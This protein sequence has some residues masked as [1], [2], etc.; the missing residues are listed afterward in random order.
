MRGRIR[1]D[2]GYEYARFVAGDAF[3]CSGLDFRVRAGT[4]QS[5]DLVL[6]WRTPGGG[7]VPVAFDALGLI[8]DFLYDNEDRLYRPDRGYMGGEKV[9]Q[10]LNESIRKGHEIAWRNVQWEKR[11]S[12]TRA[13]GA[14]NPTPTLFDDEDAA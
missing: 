2:F 10:Y 5:D 1:P 6:D 12:G 9:R 3:R 11:M 7:W 14:P 4:K 13:V 8:T